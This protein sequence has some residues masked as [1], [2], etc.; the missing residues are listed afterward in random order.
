VSDKQVIETIYGKFHKYEIVKSPG[1]ILT[2][3]SFSIYRDG[4]YYKGS[5]A[6]LADAVAA[7]KREG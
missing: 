2:S 4:K 5:Y 3:P 1:G 7:A 6:S